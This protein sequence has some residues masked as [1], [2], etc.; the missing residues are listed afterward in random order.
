MTYPGKRSRTS[1]GAACI[2]N[3]CRISRPGIAPCGLPGCGRY[4]SFRSL[5][6]RWLAASHWMIASRGTTA[7]SHVLP[8]GST[9][10]TPTCRQSSRSTIPEGTE[11]AT[12]S[13]HSPGSTGIM[14]R[15]PCGPGL[16]KPG[17]AAIS[18][19]PDAITAAAAS[20]AVMFTFEHASR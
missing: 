14:T 15:R 13:S 10:R 4:T 5:N 1:R 18:Q 17:I 3:T 12:N 19:M 9:P 6:S 11:T 7:R 16:L 8:A 20:A 2:H